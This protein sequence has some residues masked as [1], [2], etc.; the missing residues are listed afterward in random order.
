[1]RDNGV[2][3][4]LRLT[5]RHFDPPN[6]PPQGLHFGG[7]P[8]PGEAAMPGALEKLVVLDLTSHLSGPYAAMMLADDGA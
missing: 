7:G 2:C 6:H 1:M 3:A 8:R 5:R 4:G